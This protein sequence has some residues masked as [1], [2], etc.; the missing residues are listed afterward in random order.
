MVPQAMNRQRLI[1]AG[2]ITGMGMGGFL[3]GIAFHQIFQLHNMLSAKV[4]TDTLRNVEINM[5]WD[6]LFHTLTWLMTALG[7][8]LLWN[9]GKH[10]DR[11]WSGKTFSG[12]LILGWGLFNVVEGILDHH[13][14][15]IHHVVQRLGL[16]IFDYAFVG[17]GLLLIFIGWKAMRLGRQD[18]LIGRSSNGYASCR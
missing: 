2:T 5:V 8:A 1:A 7:I 11:A 12:S 6:G 10:R 16:S 9:A 15:G 14:L 3:D 4:P 17:S 18:T 13:I